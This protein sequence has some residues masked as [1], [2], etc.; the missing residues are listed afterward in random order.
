MTNGDRGLT[1]CRALVREATGADAPLFE[2]L[3]A[4]ERHVVRV[5]PG[6]TRLQA[7]TGAATRDDRS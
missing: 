3:D 2:F 7:P 5:E 6:A 4:F 1:A